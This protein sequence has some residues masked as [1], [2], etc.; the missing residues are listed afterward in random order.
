[1]QSFVLVRLLQTLRR[2]PVLLLPLGSIGIEQLLECLLLLFAHRV[3][4]VRL[5]WELSGL[6]L[7]DEVVDPILDGMAD[8]RVLLAE[9]WHELFVMR[10]AQHAQ[11]VMEHQHL[12]GRVP[13]RPDSDC[14][15]LQ[16]LRD[17]LCDIG[18]D[19]FNDDGKA[20]GILQT[21]CLVHQ[22]SRTHR[23]PALCAE[24]ADDA[25]CLRRQTDVSHHSNTTLNDLLCRD[26]PAD[27]PT[28]NFD[29]IA[30]TL[31]HK[32]ERIP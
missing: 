6:H 29:S 7:R 16:A 15:D 4:R 1:M 28:F 2:L 22:L 14:G 8:L 27:A 21:Q 12:A 19:A 26:G 17:G 13:S 10:M 5:A 3:R 11:H 18:R 30:T 23:R 32:M 9:L 31:L 25:D 20:T 24:A